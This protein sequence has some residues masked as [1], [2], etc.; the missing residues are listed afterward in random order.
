MFLV[1]KDGNFIGAY[2]NEIEIANEHVKPIVNTDGS[3]NQSVAN[4]YINYKGNKVVEIRDKN[5]ANQAI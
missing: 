5:Y 2:H 4:E 1:F 3:V